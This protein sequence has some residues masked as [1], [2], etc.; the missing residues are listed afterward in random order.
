MNPADPRPAHVQDAK[1]VSEAF[2]RVRLAEHQYEMRGREALDAMR[3]AGRELA[4]LKKKCPRGGW[5]AMIEKHMPGKRTFVYRALSVYNNWALVWR[6]GSLTEALRIIAGT[7]GEEQETGPA[8]GEPEDPN[9]L[10]LR[11]EMRTQ[12]DE[13]EGEVETPSRAPPPDFP[14]REP[15][16][17][18]STAIRLLV[19]IREI[20]SE[21]YS[22]PELRPV[23]DESS[24]RRASILTWKHDGGIVRH[25][26]LE[27]GGEVGVKRMS[28][29][30]LTL[31]I[32]QFVAMKAQLA[33]TGRGQE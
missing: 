7:E 14:P 2:S 10:R 31:L 19:R 33:N 9:V 29:E 15:G 18:L 1:A 6:A 11:N 17:E 25:G 32:E 20:V 27:G 30:A 13:P 22:D 3:E 4:V 12:V 16:E 8:E 21:L 28:N 23:M 26:T 24:L 5:L